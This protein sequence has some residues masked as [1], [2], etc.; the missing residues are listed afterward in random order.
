MICVQERIKLRRNKTLKKVSNLNELGSCVLLSFSPEPTSLNIS[1]LIKLS[2]LSI[3]NIA[4]LSKSILYNKNNQRWV[5]YQVSDFT[6]NMYRVHEVA[7]I[8]GYIYFRAVHRCC[9]LQISIINRINHM[10]KTW[11]RC[12]FWSVNYNFFLILYLKISD[13]FCII[14]IIGGELFMYQ[15]SL[16]I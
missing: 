13:I 3:R 8:L 14:K 6:K 15:V 5:M 2:I 10:R 11:M 12:T 4:C 1:G 9:I 7:E 16:P